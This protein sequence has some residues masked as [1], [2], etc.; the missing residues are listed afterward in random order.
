MLL[1]PRRQ[2]RLTLL[3]VAA[4]LAADSCYGGLPHSPR[5]V[6]ELLEFVNTTQTHPS[7]SSVPN[8]RLRQHESTQNRA[9][10][11]SKPDCMC[12]LNYDPVCGKDGKTYGNQCLADCQG[13]KVAHTGECKH[14]PSWRTFMDPSSGVLLRAHCSRTHVFS[15][16][17]QGK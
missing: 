11:H 8:C 9:A 14:S 12:T 1:P 13:E 7:L 4:L 17:G 6:S 16:T 2:Q 15:N 3:A 5:P 10:G